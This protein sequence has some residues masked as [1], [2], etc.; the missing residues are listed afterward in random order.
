MGEKKLIIIDNI[1]TNS[2]NKNPLL[3]EEI[4]K[5]LEK[6]PETNIIIFNSISHDK[7]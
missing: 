4:A 1:P 5:I 2:K 6:I 7:R 3:E